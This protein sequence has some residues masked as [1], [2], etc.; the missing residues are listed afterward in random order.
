MATLG[1]LL[2]FLLLGGRLT[3]TLAKLPRY[4]GDVAQEVPSILL[5]VLLISVIVVLPLIFCLGVVMT[6]KIAGPVKHFEDYLGQIARG[7]KVE[8]C[9]IRKGDELQ[10]LCN[11]LNEAIARLRSDAEPKDGSPTQEQADLKIRLVAAALPTPETTQGAE[12]E[13]VVG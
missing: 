6:H 2:Q 13:D 8:P 10:D 9:R 5:S 11:G 7:E 12:P 4:G 1:L 3:G